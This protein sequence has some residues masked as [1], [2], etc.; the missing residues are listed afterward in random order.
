MI[1]RETRLIATLRLKTISKMPVMDTANAIARPGVIGTLG[2][3]Y[4]IGLSSGLR[5]LSNARVQLRAT[6]ATGAS[7]FHSQRNF[8]G[9]HTC[10]LTRA[11]VCCNVR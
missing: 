2:K 4:V 11:L 7:P 1:G 10:S 3:S 6:D 8:A 5:R 9:D